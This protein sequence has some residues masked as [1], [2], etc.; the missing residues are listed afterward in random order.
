[1]LALGLVTAAL[2]G[3]VARKATAAS[4]VAL[5]ERG[6]AVLVWLAEHKKP[7]TPRSRAYVRRHYTRMV[8]RGLRSAG[9]YWPLLCIHSHES[10][11]WRIENPPYSGGF[12]EDQSFQ[13][14]YGPEFLRTWGSAGNWPIPIQF[15]SA[16]RAYRVRGWSPWPNTSRMCGL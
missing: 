5:T 6:S 12:Q 10:T 16:Y 7:G 1:V 9:V 15:V 4:P 14:S 2:I 11:D 8:F 3:L 13:R